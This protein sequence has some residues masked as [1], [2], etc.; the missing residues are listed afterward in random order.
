MKRKGLIL[1][2][3]ALLPCA[4]LT[5]AETL[6]L[7]LEEAIFLGLANSTGI[8][9][10][11]LAV[12]KARVDIQAARSSYFPSLSAGVNWI[13]LFEEIEPTP[14]IG[15]YTIP[16]DPV[17]LS[18]DL[19]QT[20]YTFGKIKNSVRIA[21]EGLKLA[22]LD[23]TEEKRSL[24]NQIQRAFYGYILAGEVVQ[25][26]GQ[27]LSSKLDALEVAKKK[28][29]AGI[30][31]DFEVLQAEADVESFKP[32]VIST[33][34]Q[35]KITLLT[36]KNL[37]GIEEEDETEIEPAGSLEL[38]DILFRK[39][40]LVKTALENKYDIKSFNQRRRLVE[41]QKQ[42]TRSSRLPT[43]TAS[44]VYRLTS[45]LDSATG[46]NKY[47]GKDSW[48]GTLSGEINVQIPVSPFFP[49]SMENAE[50]KKSLIEL[51]ELK[52]G[53]DSLISGLKLNIET[54]LLKLE[55][56]KLK[57]TSSRKGVELSQRLYDSAEEQYARG[58]ISTIGLK[59]AQLGLNSAQL[60]YIQTIFNYKMAVIDLMDAVGVN[61]F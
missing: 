11:A 33:Q 45:G 51:E 42:L 34:N 48:N 50:N 56:E 32:T 9:S 13:H 28:F 22:E 46:K 25:I 8:K 12:L 38:D 54:I 14:I 19:G 44:L 23:L 30:S 17:T 31:S 21:G 39:N 35:V 29:A 15:G 41:I 55:E 20:L 49:W 5:A 1:L 10:K 40:E 43:I 59:D 27:T 18:L 3:I 4:S 6:R 61:H 24:V 37:L 26:N 47:W 60:A 52:L 36:V 58:V 7:S 53:Y 57:I 16:R 2:L